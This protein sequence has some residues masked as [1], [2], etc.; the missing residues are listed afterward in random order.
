MFPLCFL[1]Y[2]IGSDGAALERPEVDVR[3]KDSDYT[4]MLIW[5]HLGQFAIIW[6]S[7]GPSGLS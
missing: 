4:T 3:N 6:I 1:V 7:L 2:L 5:D